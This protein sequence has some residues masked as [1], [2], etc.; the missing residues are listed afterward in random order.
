MSQHVPASA[1]PFH[2]FALRRTAPLG[3]IGRRVAP[4]YGAVAYA[5]F[6]ASFS[7]AIGFVG[8]WI[9]PK[10]I[11]SGASGPVGR[12]L[13][14]N[15]A[16]LGLFAVQHTVMAR[17]GFKRWLTR[18]VPASME[19]STFVLAASAALGL[20][21]WQWRPLPQI[22]WHAGTPAISWGLQALSLAGW[23]LAIV[24]TFLISHFDLFGLRQVWLGATNRSYEPVG[25]R[26]IGPYRL[27][28]HP[29]MVG[30]LIG[31]WATPTMTLGHLFFSIMTTLY[32]LV[33]VWFEERDLV[34]EH[35]EA[36]E[37]YRRRVRGF[38]PM[39]RRAA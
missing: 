32:I 27:V 21:M 31:F 29:L 8:N 23:A 39:P 26:L 22:V 12:S 15:A 18:C 24:S 35:G 3:P 5:A 38:V 19:R 10:T 33:G 7:Y 16:L 25:F 13:L 28:R 17:P 20:M 1:C 11:D 34:R 2:G 6:V 36:Y 30:L 4:A 14:V 37:S 9:V